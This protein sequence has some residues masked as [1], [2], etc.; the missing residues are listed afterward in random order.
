M[1][2]NKKLASSIFFFL[3]SLIAN[4]KG[5]KNGNI[6]NEYKEPPPFH[7]ILIPSQ[8]LINGLY[9]KIFITGVYIELNNRYTSL[10]L[11]CVSKDVALSA[12]LG[13]E[14]TIYALGNSEKAA[15]RRPKKIIPIY[16]ISIKTIDFNSSNL[17]IHIYL[18]SIYKQRKG[19]NIYIK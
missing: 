19:T 13:I 15:N 12:N 8:E 14:N 6:I 18:K 7:P 16:L 3:L 2:N 5:I 11:R 4:N 17:F 1:N 9:E 10:K